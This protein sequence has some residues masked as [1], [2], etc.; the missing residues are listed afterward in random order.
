MRAH[1]PPS[2]PEAMFQDGA[3]ED[4]A[5]P[6]CLSCSTSLN[7]MM[8]PLFYRGWICGS[9]SHVTN[10]KQNLASTMVLVTYSQGYSRIAQDS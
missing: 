6:L 7:R 4:V 3:I 8:L 1:W 9:Q 5:I 10:K 2:C